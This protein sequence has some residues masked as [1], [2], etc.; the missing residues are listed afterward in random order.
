MAEFKQ[1]Y[2][3][4]LLPTERADGSLA[5]TLIARRSFTIPDDDPTCQPLQDE[6]QAPLLLEDRYDIGDADSA[7]PTLEYEVVP[8]KAL[9]DVIV[10][11]KTYSPSGK[12]EAQWECAV[13]IGT[14]LRRLQVCGPRVCRFTQPQKRS[15]KLVSQPPKFSAPDP[16][17]EVALTLSLAYGGQTWVIP[18]EETLRV[19]RQVQEVMD[20]ELA[21]KKAAK[22][23]QKA[24]KVEAEAKAQK[25]AADKEFLEAPVGDLDEQD[26]KLNR[27][28]GEFGYDDDG[29]RVWGEATSKKG[30]AVMDL[31]AFAAWQADLDEKADE[32][33]IAEPPKAKSSKRANA[34]GEV[35]EIDDGVAILDDETL[36]EELAKSATDQE[37][38]KSAQSE[39]AKRRRKE[40]VVV[41]DGT[42]V[43]S[44]MDDEQL[45]EWE[46][47]LQDRLTEQDAETL[48]VLNAE[49]IARKKALEAKLE[50]FPKLPC[51]TNPFGLGFVVSNVKELIEGMPLPQL[52]DPDAP[53]T[54]KDLLQDLLALDKVPLP[55][56]FSVWPRHA[57]PRIEFAG[58]YPS[59]L[60]DYD[61]RL[62]QQKREIDLDDE[63]EVSALRELEK[64]GVPGQ[65]RANYFNSAAPTLQL[66]GVYGDEEIT[67]TNLTKTGTLYFR[68]PGRAVVAELERGQ[69][70][71]RVDM[72]LDTV[73]IEPDERLVT[74]LWRAHFPFASWQ[75]LGTYPG[76]VGWVL[77]LDLDDKKRD[78]W[79]ASVAAKRSDGTA[80]LDIS[81]LEKTDEYW[82]TISNERK[83][84]EAAAAAVEGTQ[85]LDIER[86][87]LYRQVEDD[88]WVQEASD[89]TVDEDAFA[90]KEAEEQA[91]L[92]EKNAAVKRL[93]EQDK[94]E[95]ERREE[96][97]TAVK[98][99]KKIPPPDS[100][101][102]AA[103]LK[104]AK[105][106]RS[107]TSAKPKA[108]GKTKTPAKPKAAPKRAGRKVAAPAK[109]KSSR[110][111]S[112][113]GTSK[114]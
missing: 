7:P 62:E 33:A 83:S 84:K 43:I 64:R 13:Q 97:A 53:L 109:P 92:E 69:G 37:E 104:K 101:K 19:Q 89:G 95:Q 87:G 16:V 10:V 44:A 112:P 93:E 55:A 59:E 96:I 57:T 80:M 67:L 58:E 22:A 105:A 90:Q 14:V 81:E 3:V 34:K 12:P 107:K 28:W 66:E 100:E 63:D 5:V 30:T 54:P 31:D 26:A 35:L 91:W 39:A 114:K 40:S 70:V 48:A 27:A 42:R 106:A 47:S 75:E 79:D 8:E 50:E 1:G 72:K 23:A 52:E 61:K 51:P 18:D 32:Q 78:E 6:E 108:S 60:K 73:V 46:E 36:A 103:Q 45:E 29:V 21:D 15:G 94:A 74:L 98:A 68:L 110:A 82:K 71:E 38:L 2:W 76:M 25:E 24:A 102:S 20:V 4:E 56:G 86:M 49:A 113:R 65:M 88:D 85:A 9:C 41:N 17:A 11:G 77:D 111:K 99:N